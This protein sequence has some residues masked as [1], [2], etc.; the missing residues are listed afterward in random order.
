MS[1][2]WDDS[3]ELGFDVIDQ[4]H[5]GLVER[6]DKLSKAAQEGT[7]HELIEELSFFLLEYAQKHFEAEE[8]IMEEY[9]YSKIETQRTEHAAFTRDANELKSTIEQNGATREVAIAATGKLLRWI[10]Q[11]IK[12]HDKEM[13]AYIK[14]CISL[15]EKSLKHYKKDTAPLWL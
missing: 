13:V 5:K 10:I 2:Q 7:S 9:V 8:K 1:L 14:E 3:L 15:R 12:K 6:F 4:Q 11:H